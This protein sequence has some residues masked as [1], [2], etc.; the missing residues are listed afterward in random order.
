[1]QHLKLNDEEYGFWQ[2]H[3]EDIIEM[4]ESFIEK[5]NTECEELFG[6]VHL[7]NYQTQNESFQSTF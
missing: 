5:R 3:T 6:H 2:Y 4:L 1:M 7:E